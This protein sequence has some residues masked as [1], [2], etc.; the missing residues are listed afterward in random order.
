MG[1]LEKK[2]ASEFKLENAFDAIK[3]HN[4]EM[5]EKNKLILWQNH[6]AKFKYMIRDNNEN[7]SRFLM[8]VPLVQ[9]KVPKKPL[10][11]TISKEVNLETLE[12]KTVLELVN[13]KKNKTNRVTKK[14]P[15]KKSA[16]KESAKKESAKKESAKKESVK[17]ESVKKPA[18]K[19]PAKKQT[20]KSKDSCMF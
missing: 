8:V 1:N 20:S 18:K 13:E 16:K 19:E 5:E 10:F 17:K 4:K 3:K 12:F 15:V 9:P 7:N 6:D 11:V 14:E 2:I